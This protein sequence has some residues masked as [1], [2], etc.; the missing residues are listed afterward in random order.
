MNWFNTLPYE[1]RRKIILTVCLALDYFVVLLVALSFLYDRIILAPDYEI[2][3]LII[4]SMFA[5]MVSFAKEKTH[6]KA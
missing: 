5:L 2:L 4:F 6:D 1:I 3:F